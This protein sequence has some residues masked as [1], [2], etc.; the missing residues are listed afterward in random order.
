MVV[1]LFKI[2]DSVVSWGHSSPE[3][4]SDVQKE[5]AGVLEKMNNSQQ[6][7]VCKTAAFLQKFRQRDLLG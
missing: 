3:S 7:T 2:S 4:R 6:L 5:V 1:A